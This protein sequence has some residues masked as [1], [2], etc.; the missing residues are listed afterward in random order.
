MR[1]TTP[2]SRIG[3]P[4]AVL[5]SLG[6][7][8][9]E[10]GEDAQSDVATTASSL[11]GLAGLDDAQPHSRE[12]ALPPPAISLS[13]RPP[14]P[15]PTA[16]AR[17]AAGAD[18]AMARAADSASVLPREHR[19]ARPRN[20]FSLPANGKSWRCASTAALAAPGFDVWSA[21]EPLDAASLLFTSAGKPRDRHHLRRAPRRCAADDGGVAGARCAVLRWT[22]RQSGTTSLRALLYMD[23]IYGFLPANRASREQEADECPPEA[24]AGFRPWSAPGD[25]ESCG[26]RLQGA[27]EHRHLVAGPP[28]DGARQGPD[29]P[30]RSRRRV[31]GTRSAGDRSH[32]SP[33]CEPVCSSC[34]TCTTRHRRRSRR[35][36][37]SRICAGRWDARSCAGLRA[38]RITTSAATPPPLPTPAAPSPAASTVK[39]LVPAGVEEMR[40]ARATRAILRSTRLRSTEQRACSTPTRSA[41]STSRAASRRSSR[42]RAARSR[43]TGN[44][45]RRRRV[46]PEKSGAAICDRSGTAS[47]ASH[48][49]A[50]DKKRYAAW[51]KDFETWVARAQPLERSIR[52][53]S[54]K[55]VSKTRR[56]RARLPGSPPT[57]RPRDAA[58]PRSRSSD[59]R[60]RRRSRVCR[61]KARKAE[62]SRRQGT[63]AGV[64]AESLQTAVSFGAT[65]AR[66]AD[67]TTCGLAVHARPRD[68]GGPRCRPIGQG[69]NSGR[70][71]GSGTHAGGA[72]GAH[73]ARDRTPAGSC[74]ARRGDTGR[75]GR[76]ND[77]RSNRSEAGWTSGSSRSPGSL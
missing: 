46:R 6:A 77:R 69:K 43:L 17:Q 59:S 21:G 41:A 27:V 32:V 36:G 8:A 76:R 60:T 39:P 63:A 18:L 68:D 56:I 3:T 38:R 64:A 62:E 34:T 61:K 25:A 58:M 72:G 5:G 7:A 50:L 44:V 19:R 30:R 1:R 22:R 47:A 14:P 9:H 33:R 31:V 13:S 28:A 74:G 71:Q 52:W 53:P 42:S 24:G 70:R 67:G 26:S 23:E 75:R 15:S 55:L 20:V 65:D 4:L 48:P 40:A 66:R 49:A 73:L 2:G 51:T 54:M 16:S 29:A 57:C 12:Q 11:L 37:H 35:G 45:R 10:P